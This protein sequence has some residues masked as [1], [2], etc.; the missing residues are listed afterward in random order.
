MNCG[1]VQKK[2]LSRLSTVEL[3]CGGS[4]E[5]TTIIVQTGRKGR[6]VEVETARTTKA[7]DVTT[8]EGPVVAPEKSVTSEST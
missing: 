6:T 3:A 2:G 1:L 8:E 7:T 5:V 4:K